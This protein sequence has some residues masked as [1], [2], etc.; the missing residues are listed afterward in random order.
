MDASRKNLTRSDRLGVLGGTFDPVH[1]GH[2]AIARAAL[3][4]HALSRI[5]LM[6]A[7][8][9]PHKDGGIAP[10][11]D[12]LEMVRIA[13]AGDPHLEASDLEVRR[14]G[15]SFTVET[16]AALAARH[17]GAELFFI[18]GEDTVLELPGWRESARILSLARIVAV[19]REGPRHRFDAALYP[20][21]PPEVLEQ[22]EKDRVEMEPV[23]IAS[24]DI[25]KA[26]AKGDPFDRWL[27]AGVG[28]Y[29]RTKKLYGYG[30]S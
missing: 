21:I 20:G 27:P 9:P 13:C 19:H 22:C 18:L 4:A 5:L 10:A 12:R 8:R 16:L 17:R 24:R 7:A 15:I 25:R 3:E 14:G 26:I 29:I 2:L 28:E 30:R 11:A 1:M 23:P 6:P